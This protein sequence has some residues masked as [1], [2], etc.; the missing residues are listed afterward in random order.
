MLRFTG[1]QQNEHYPAAARV[2]DADYLVT[3]PVQDNFG[4]DCSAPVTRT[5]SDRS[6]LANPLVAK[7][8]TFVQL[9]A[10][11]IGAL[12][13]LCR[14]PKSYRAEQILIHE[15]SSIG[16]VCL[17]VEGLACRYKLLPG[18][19]R[20]IMGYLIPGDLC[21]V[22]FVVFNKPDH[23]VALVGDSVV[24]R[25]PVHAIM[26]LIIRYP[27]IER[28]M[29]LASLIDNAILREWLLNI[30]QRSALQRLSHF[31]CEM[32]SRL[33]AIGRVN[34]DGSFE[35]AANQ[36]TLADTIGLTSVH[37]NRTLQRLRSGGLIRLCHR[38]LT[39]LDKNRL[40]AIAEFDEGYLRV[41]RPQE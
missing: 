4:R 7:L 12:E 39:I 17:I 29:S 30:G 36:V 15:G 21:D 31:F 19:R 22:H 6:P 20:Q 16:H 11:E 28:A 10:E 1:S 33:N 23:S 32:S 37:I 26:E 41:G 27:R 9:G 8:E 38:R 14:N 35:L 3:E 34:E 5:W 13:A 2:N 18:G 24:V 40:A 25:I